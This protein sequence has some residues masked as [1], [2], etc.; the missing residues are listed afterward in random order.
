MLPSKAC[1]L[2]HKMLARITA[3]TEVTLSNSFKP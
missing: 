2:K 1:K 3:Y